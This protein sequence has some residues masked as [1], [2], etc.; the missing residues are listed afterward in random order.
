MW[1]SIYTVEARAG[2]EMEV[3]GRE[4]VLH[5][6]IS[7]LRGPRLPFL[8]ARV[9]LLVAF[10]CILLFAFIPSAVGDHVGDSRSDVPIFA[11]LALASLSLGSVL[12]VAF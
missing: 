1:P 5:L 10:P 3:G 12:L 9:A 4:G 11:C 7:L 6:K 2:I 8:T